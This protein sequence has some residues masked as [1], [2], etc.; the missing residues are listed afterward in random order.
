MPSSSATSFASAQ[1]PEADRDLLFNLSLDLL[2]I[3]GLDGYFKQVNP[4]WTRVLGW[5]PEELLARP[6]ADFM[7][8]DDRERT[9]KA[10]DGLAQGIPVR[11]LENRYLCKDGSYRWLSWQ[12]NIAPGAT[13]VF[14]VARDITAQRQAD[15]ERMV[16]SKLESTGTLAGGIA[17]DFNNLLASL[18]LN[19]EMVAMIAPVT[20]QQRQL[21]KQSLEAVHTGQALTQQL[22]TFAQSDSSVRHPS[23]LKVLLQQ[24]M[25]L[26]LSGSNV[27]G[28]SRIAPDLWAVEV[29]E[30]QFSQVIR[31]LILNAREAIPAGGT[32][33]L[34]AEN[35]IIDATRGL[36][37]PPGDYVHIHVSDEGPGIDPDTLPKVFDPYFSTKARGP[38]KGMGLGLT[39]CHAVV[40]KHGGLISIDSHP[41]RGTSV[42]C[43]LPASQLPPPAPAVPPPIEPVSS[44]RILV[45][46]DEQALREIMAQTLARIGYTA[47]LAK[48]GQEAVARYEEARNSGHPFA[49]VLLD[50]TV[51]GGMGGSETMKA[52]CQRDPSVRG[53]LMTGYNH[54]VT[55]RDHAVHGF[56]AALAK[57][58]SVDS[59]RQTLAEVLGTRPAL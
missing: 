33:R 45:M 46:E 27:R 24:S 23:D 4:S 6:V 49:A 32:V 28:E 52:L 26:A 40:K 14:A 7:H 10:R 22:I 55:L 30:S 16:L 57:P 18:S 8:P 59:L 47:E 13:T 21:L 5:S 48:D 56:K 11:G 37:L 51:R 54:E 25:N 35:E 1:T 43:H 38:Q 31:N 12:S 17:H 39:I 53:V 42:H 20:D 9:L 34:Q 50:L 15:Q 29:N 58:F 19:L 44:K 3:A 41:G 2:C 36:D